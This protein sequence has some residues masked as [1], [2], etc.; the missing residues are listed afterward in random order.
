MIMITIK[1]TNCWTFSWMLASSG[2][3]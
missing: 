1:I 3:S 2:R